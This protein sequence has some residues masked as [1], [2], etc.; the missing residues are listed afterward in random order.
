MKITFIGDIMAEPPVLKAA[1][2]KD[3]SYNFDGVFEYVKPLLAEADFVAGNLETPL[4]SESAKYSQNHFCFN[5]PDSYV[6]A[7]K[8]AGIGMVATS[9]N[10]TFDRGYEGMERTV[11]VMEEK[12]MGYH[13]TALRGSEHR[14]AFY[15]TVGDT[16]IAIIAYTY[17]TNYGSDSGGLALAEGEYAGTVNLLRPQ[18]E[19]VYL[20]GVVHELDWLDKAFPNMHPDRKG[21]LKKRLGMCHVY[22]RSDDRLN[23]ETCAPHIRQMQE[24]IRKAKENADLVIFYPHM[25]GQF[26][27]KPGYISQYV[28]EKALEAEPDAIIASHAHCPQLATF[29]GGVPVAYSIGNFNMS[30]L[31]SYTYPEHLSQY[32]LAMHLY[33]EDKKIQKVTFSMLLNHAKR[34]TQI[35]GYP[36]DDLYKTLNKEKEKQQ[37]IKDIQKLYSMV[38]GKILTEPFVRREYEL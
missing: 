32:G 23:K 26:N 7:C 28:V 6:D 29:I 35:A 37:L 10:H 25:G 1:K 31:S 36:V 38:T 33:V 21:M 30:P 24:D 12:G 16:K 14:E 34:G 2:Q 27:L 15:T 20:P 18:Q 8:N 3:G 19:S 4:A 17:G 13:G 22:T 11:R 9:N 5:A